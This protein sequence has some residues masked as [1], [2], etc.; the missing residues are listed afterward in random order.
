MT[1]LVSRVLHQPVQEKSLRKILQDHCEAGNMAH[2]IQMLPA[3]SLG[4]LLHY[5]VWFQQKSLSRLAHHPCSTPTRSSA[6]IVWCFL[7]LQMY[8]CSPFSDKEWH[9]RLAMIMN[10]MVIILPTYLGGI[11]RANVLLDS[12]VALACYRKS[13]KGRLPGSH[14]SRQKKRERHSDYDR[15]FRH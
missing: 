6:S 15:R 2:I 12:A 9:T 13:S 3:T 1:S 14:S 8:Q 11:S 7:F 10:A 4:L 5:C